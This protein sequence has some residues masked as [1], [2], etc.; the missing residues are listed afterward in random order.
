MGVQ[1][2][3]AAGWRTRSAKNMFIRHVLQ[4][5]E[6]GGSAAWRGFNAGQVARP[7]RLLC[8]ASGAQFCCNIARQQESTMEQF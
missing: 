3:G 7:G 2:L 6:S 8:R 1:R 4:H 5:G